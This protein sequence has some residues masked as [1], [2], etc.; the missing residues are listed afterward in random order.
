MLRDCVSDQRSP[1]WLAAAVSR[2]K[3]RTV[4]KSWKRLSET[5]QLPA[6]RTQAMPSIDLG[7]FGS[8]GLDGF[9]VQTSLL[10]LRFPFNHAI[11]SLRYSLDH[12]VHWNILEPFDLRVQLLFSPG[13]RDVFFDARGRQSSLARRN[14]SN[15][16]SDDLFV[17]KGHHG[18]HV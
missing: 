3:G 12:N 5:I 4:V 7:R 6:K 10:L 8:H 17:P 18:V 9:G 13:A 2:N 14:Y 16:S 1:V 11:H 15:G